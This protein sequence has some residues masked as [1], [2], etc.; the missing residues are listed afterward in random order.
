MTDGLPSAVIVD[1]D[2]TVASHE[3]LRGHFEYEKA[4]NDAP[5]DAIVRLVQLLGEHHTIIFMSGRENFSRQT[6]IE[7]LYRHGLSSWHKLLMREAGDHRKDSI[8][9]RELYETHVKGQYE[10]ELVLD[11]R[12]QV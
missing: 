7:W 9:K 11:D 8:V 12:N 10:V 4:G 6:T 3:G 2:G 5:I 1:I